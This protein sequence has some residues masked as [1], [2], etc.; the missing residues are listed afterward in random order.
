MLSSYRHLNPGNQRDIL[1]NWRRIELNESKSRENNLII[2][3]VPLAMM[4]TKE[5]LDETMKKFLLEGLNFSPAIAESILA[6]I[7]IMHKLRIAGGAFIVRFAKVS[8]IRQIYSRVSNLRNWKF[9][10]SCQYSAQVTSDKTPTQQ[11]VYRALLDLSKL[12][13]SQ[14]KNVKLRDHR[15]LVIDGVFKSGSDLKLQYNLVW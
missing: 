15:G 2:R 13:R 8:T 12:L 14:G 7:S 4:E 1:A 5:K 11:K 6:D 9:A 3:N 10:D